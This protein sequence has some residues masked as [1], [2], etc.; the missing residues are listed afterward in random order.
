MFTRALQQIQAR[1]DA[2]DDIDWLMQIGSTLVRA[3][4][5][6]ATTGRKRGG[7][8][9]TNRTI[10]PSVDPEEELA[11]KIHLACG[12][13][14]RPLAILVTPGQHHERAI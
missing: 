14:G 12:G 6:A 5:H 8:R 2:A 10:T 1:A 3:H 9:R 13:R 11:T 7:I 4:Q